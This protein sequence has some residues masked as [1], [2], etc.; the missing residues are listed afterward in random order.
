MVSGLEKACSSSKTDSK[1]ETHV[2]PV[3]DCSWARD[4]SDWFP[5]LNRWIDHAS[6]RMSS[7]L[8]LMPK[9]FFT[10]EPLDVFGTPVPSVFD[11]VDRHMENLRREMEESIKAMGVGAHDKVAVPTGDAAGQ[12]GYLTDAYEPGKDGHARYNVQDFKPEDVEVSTR[13]NCLV[14]HGK[15]KE[16]LPDGGVRTREFCRSIVVPEKVNKDDFH[17]T[18]TSDGVLVVEAPVKEPDYSAIKFDDDRKLC[19]AAKPHGDATA[20]KE[21]AVT[22]K[23]GVVVVGD[24]EHR[25]LHLEVPVDSHLEPKDIT[26]RMDANSVRISGTHAA[27]HDEKTD[28]GEVHSAEAA[29]FCRTYAVP[30][31]IDACSATAVLKDNRLIRY[32]VEDFQPADLEVSTRGNCLVVHGKRKEDLPDGGVRTREFCRSIVI[33]EKVNKDDFHASLTSDGVLLVEAPV[34][35]PDYSVYRFDDDRKFCLTAKP[36]EDLPV[37]MELAVTG[38]DG[39]VVM[40]DAEHRKLHLEVPVDSHLGPKDITIRMDANSVRISGTHAEKHDE[41]T[42]SGEIHS[43]E[44]TRFCKSFAIPRAIDACSANAVLKDNRLVLEAPLIKF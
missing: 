41:K 29:H 18:L 8:A 34:K 16:D 40:G 37:G 33:P 4:R 13:G 19:V 26:I 15:R 36:H 42:T 22:G 12:L 31:T 14:V 21:L 38:K 23:D 35:E 2:V 24:A 39:A 44:R 5:Q 25:K 30:Q 32:N 1:A 28:A 27:K 7:D 3:E 17:A 10:L 43:S 20:G 11:F 6:R 9:N